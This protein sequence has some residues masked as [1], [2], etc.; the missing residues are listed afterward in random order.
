MARPKYGRGEQTA[1]ERIVET[2]WR[3][4]EDGPDEKVGVRG[5]VRAS[6]VN[7]NTF[8]YHFEDV[9]DLV[10][11]AT[12][13][14]LDPAFLAEML[15]QVRG[16]AVRARLRDADFQVP[17]GRVRTIAHAKGTPELQDA[18][19]EALVSTWADV[20][21]FDRDMLDKSQRV[22]LEFTLGGIVSVLAYVGEDGSEPAYDQVASSGVPQAVAVVF[23]GLAK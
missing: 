4:V 12:R 16:A 3:M 21:G 20:L 8:Y 9:D 19:R 13:E 2:F 14:V 17:L 11:Q 22:A 15:S 18:L 5:L 7:K 23:E 10:R 1:R 6:G